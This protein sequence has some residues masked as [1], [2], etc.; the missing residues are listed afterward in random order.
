MP[1]LRGKQK[2][3]K[4][5]EDAAVNF[6]IRGGHTILER[7]YRLQFAEIDII[8]LRENLVFFT[9]VKHWNSSLFAHPLETFNK[10]K[11][12]KMKLAAEIYLSRHVSLKRCFVS[13]CLAF[14]NEKREL[15][16]YRNLF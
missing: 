11:E 2:K 4:L 12:T 3:G 13:F 10:K 14:L 7:N 9:E 6:L 8:S 1:D 15:V 16:F 5:G